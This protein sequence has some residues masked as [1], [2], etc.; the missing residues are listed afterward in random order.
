M[1]QKILLEA[2]DIKKN[3]GDRA[4]LHPDRLCVYEGQRIGLIGE[5]GAGKSTLLNI[6]SGEASPE[7]GK[8]HRFCEIGIIHQMGQTE[9]DISPQM[10]SRFHTQADRTTL[11]GGEKTRRRI[12]AAF[13]KNVPLLFA[14]EPTTDLDSEGIALLEKHLT[15]FS[16]AI[17]L[18]SH[19]RHLLDTVCNCIWHLEDGN[20]SVFPGNYTAYQ[21]ELRQRRE[22]QQDEYDQYKAEKARLEASA[23]KMLERSQQ[24][25]KTPARMGNSEARLHT[26]AATD[27]IFRITRAK[28]ALQTRLD[29][30][31]R[32]ERPRDLPEI[33]M[34]FGAQTPIGA[35]AA[36]TGRSISLKAGDKVLLTKTDFIIP[37]G[38]RT[39]LLGPNGC[40]KT[41]LLH[42]LASGS[43]LTDGIHFGGQL[44]M[45]PAVRLGWFDQ[46]HSA[47][48]DLNK[49]AL[50]N[51]MYTSIAD[52]STVRTTFA[53]LNLRGDDVFK[54]LSV[55]SGGE[56][57]KTALV[58]LL[59]SDINVLLL[60]E[61]TNHL[62]VFTLEALQELLSG[63]GGTLL[64]VSHDRS[65]TEAVASRIL[66][67]DGT[68]L[69]TFEGTL[70]EMEKQDHADT[71]RRQ[72]ELEITTLQM[73]MAALVSRMSAP[74]KGDDPL[75]LNADY[76]A[77]AE[78][79]RL[80][81][82]SL[83]PVR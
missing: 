83:P 71:D 70:S 78:Q 44:K 24:I 58:R 62:D 73:R 26:R 17:L 11:S 60:D 2:L 18:I 59:V 33:S 48:L 13:T 25:R 5:N 55:L 40:G 45:N 19:D 65:F 79:I 36:V 63:Y 9:A 41:T 64:F 46:D 69:Q 8:V 54:P 80:M 37:T 15:S 35:K 30:L 42:A 1:N 47:T 43:R 57:A 77:L 51:A 53:R 23:Q 4:L 50:A 39:A 7:S 49:S 67:F 3:Y 12:A 56:R 82:Q 75:K 72:L 31:E 66:R 6:L 32:K 61:P 34:S 21:L 27:A 68:S 38:S 16:G 52:E 10:C 20:I 28:G 29:Q 74:R 76:E 22:H 14:D 81:K